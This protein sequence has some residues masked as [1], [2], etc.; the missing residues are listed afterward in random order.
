MRT[1]QRRWF[2][3][4]IQCSSIKAS[5][6]VLLVVDP[7]LFHVSKPL[8][9]AHRLDNILAVVLIGLAFSV[10]APAVRETPRAFGISAEARFKALHHFLLSVED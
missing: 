9:E 6:L 1:R 10:A 4:V 7:A 2:F 3:S 8:I 5:F